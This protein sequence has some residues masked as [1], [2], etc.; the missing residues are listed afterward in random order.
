MTDTDTLKLAAEARAR[1]LWLYNAELDIYFS[2]D[3]VERSVW[4]G[5]EWAITEPLELVLH[6]SMQ[7]PQR[8]V[9]IDNRGHEDLATILF[10]DFV[11]VW[12]LFMVAAVVAAILL[13]PQDPTTFDNFWEAL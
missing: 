9:L 8:V 6:P 5:E 4:Q 11:M 12:G 10:L 1:G 13:G 7:P 3:E 2:A